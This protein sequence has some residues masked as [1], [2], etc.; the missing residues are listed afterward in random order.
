MQHAVRPPASAR[1]RPRSTIAVTPQELGA[2]AAASK[3]AVTLAARVKRPGFIVPLKVEVSR[4][5]VERLVT[6][7]G[8]RFQP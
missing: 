7:L 2:V 6:S 4:P 8:K 1:R 3:E 5:R